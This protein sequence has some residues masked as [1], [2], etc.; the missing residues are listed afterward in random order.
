M[1]DDFDF[2]KGLSA[3]D[4]EHLFQVDPLGQKIWVE[5]CAFHYDI[6]SFN[7]DNTHVTAYNEGRRAVIKWLMVK[8]NHFEEE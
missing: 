2:T 6:E 4:Y 3:K 5:M 1:K 7:E 8:M